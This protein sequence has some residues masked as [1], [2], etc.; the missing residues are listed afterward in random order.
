MRRHF[1]TEKEKLRIQDQECPLT[2]PRLVWAAT[3]GYPMAR[4]T[5]IVIWISFIVAFIGCVFA[6]WYY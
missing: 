3:E 1:L 6:V 5:L 4:F 2:Q